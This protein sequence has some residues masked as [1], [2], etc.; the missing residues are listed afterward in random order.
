LLAAEKSRKKNFAL[1]PGLEWQLRS[2]RRL[3]R[4]PPNRAGRT[5]RKD[6]L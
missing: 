1:C 5:N 2:E 4:D 6:F 3:K